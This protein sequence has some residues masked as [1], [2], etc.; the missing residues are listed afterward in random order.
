MTHTFY[1]GDDIAIPVQ[2]ERKTTGKT[3]KAQLRR[4]YGGVKIVDMVTTILDDDFVELSLPKEETEKLQGSYIG[5]VEM[6]NADGSVETIYPF[7]IVF[8]LDVTRSSDADLNEGDGV[9]FS[10]IKSNDFI[11][12]DEEGNEK[13]LPNITTDIAEPVN[14]KEGDIWIKIV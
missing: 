11:R 9:V 5:D 6:V 3:Y 14:P 4:D 8:K 10:A 2:D 13:R 1:R 12:V 7:R